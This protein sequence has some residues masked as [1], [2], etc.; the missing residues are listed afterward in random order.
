MHVGTTEMGAL[1]MPAFLLILIAPFF[2]DIFVEI[3]VGAQTVVRNDSGGVL[4][5]LP[6]FPVLTSHQTS[7]RHNQDINI[8][9]VISLVQMSAALHVRVHAHVLH[10][11]Q[12]CALRRIPSVPT[13]QG[14]QCRPCLAALQCCFK[15]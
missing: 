1:V 15:P 8:D 6:S 7:Q 4:C 13:P 12:P 5:P 14:P 2:I 3:V 9:V 10:S 11:G